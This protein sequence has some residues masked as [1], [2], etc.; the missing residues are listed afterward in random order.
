MSPNDFFETKL[1]KKILEAPHCL[2][3][4]G[5]RS[6]RIGVEISGAGGGNWIFVFNDQGH[7]GMEKVTEIQADCTISTSDTTF[8]GV[9]KGS[10]NVPFAFMMRKIKVKGESGLAVKLGLALQKTFLS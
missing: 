10:V 4:S 6:Q 7:V 9:L 1:S 5:I 3:H 2:E 8:E